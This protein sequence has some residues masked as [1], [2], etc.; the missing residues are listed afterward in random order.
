MTGE[1]PLATTQEERI[2]RVRLLFRL[3][4]GFDF[5]APAFH[6]EMITPPLPEGQRA[7]YWSPRAGAFAI[8]RAA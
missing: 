2:L 8:G 5:N 4:R 6:G 1:Y 3:L 7:S